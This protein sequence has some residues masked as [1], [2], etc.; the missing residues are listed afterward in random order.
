MTYPLKFRQHVLSVQK[1]EGL[2]YAQTAQRFKIGLASLVRWARQIEPATTRHKPAVKIDMQA[3]AEDVRQYPDAYQKE[4]ALRLGVSKN[5][6]CQAL[7]R[8]GLTRKKRQ[9]GTR[10]P[11]LQ[12]ESSFRPRSVSGKPKSAP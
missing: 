5:G 8:L 11:M 9:P 7:R 10:R 2:T 4:R 3:L 6:I 12:R 1:E